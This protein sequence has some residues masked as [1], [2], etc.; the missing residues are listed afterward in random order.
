MHDLHVPDDTDWKIDWR[1][2]LVEEELEVIELFDAGV[3]S[4]PVV[5]VAPPASDT[6]RIRYLDTGLFSQV[7][8]SL[9]AFLVGR[10]RAEI[11]E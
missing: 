1:D 10:R 9:A 4:E 2:D 7:S 8:P 3:T 11:T 6:V 5:E